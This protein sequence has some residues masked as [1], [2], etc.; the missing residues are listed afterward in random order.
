MTFLTLQRRYGK[1]V[2]A[3]LGKH[4]DSVVTSTRKSA[5]DAVEYLRSHRLGRSRFLPVDFVEVPKQVCQRQPT[6]LKTNGFVWLSSRLPSL[7]TFPK[8]FLLVLPSTVSA[9]MRY[10]GI[11]YS[12]IL[13]NNSITDWPHRCTIG[14]YS[15]RLTTRWSVT[16]LLQPEL[17]LSR[18][19]SAEEVRI[20][21]FRWLFGPQYHLHYSCDLERRNCWEV[22]S[23][24]G[25]FLWW[26]WRP[27]CS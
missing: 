17:L 4:C 7:P 15:L 16:T 22:W 19:E 5:T 1:A 8:T 23:Y 3:A 14:R 11:I 20:T 18:A 2:E 26:C 25:W 27:L 12:N 21:G 6:V 10:R 24:V 9:L 13:Y